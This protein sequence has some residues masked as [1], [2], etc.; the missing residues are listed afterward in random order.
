MIFKKPA[1]VLFFVLVAAASPLPA[2]LTFSETIH[3]GLDYWGISLFA[4]VVGAA[5]CMV[6]CA[7]NCCRARQ[8]AKRIRRTLSTFSSQELLDGMA[9]TVKANLDASS[10]VEA[11]IYKGTRATTQ[12]WHIIAGAAQ[13]NLLAET[14]RRSPAISLDPLIHGLVVIGASFDNPLLADH[15]E[16]SDVSTNSL[17]VIA[18]RCIADKVPLLIIYLGQ[19]KHNRQY[20]P[21]FELAILTIPSTESLF[22]DPRSRLREHHALTVEALLENF[23]HAIAAKA[24]SFATHRRNTDLYPSEKFC[25]SESNCFI[26]SLR[27]YEEDEVAVTVAPEA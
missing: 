13:T 3:M 14:I 23:G 17:S 25:K 24:R 16:H 5:G 9:G 10:E 18:N 19:D 1:R 8:R 2:T 26:E 15:S 20:L 27:N 12:S 21:A 7:V 11:L 4:A 22:D 6:K